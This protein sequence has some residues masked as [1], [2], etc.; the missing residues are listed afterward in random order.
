MRILV[1]DDDNAML[2]AY[3]TAFA[4]AL[5]QDEGAALAQMARA[6]FSE[7]IS[8]DVPS[9]PQVESSNDFSDVSYAT[10]GLEAIELVE[11]SCR[12]GRP[13]QVIFLDMRMPPGISGKEAAR[14]IRQID[15]DVNIVMVTGYSDH[16]PLD[17]ASVAGPLSKLYYIA[18]PF[19][20]DEV[21]Q[22]A[23]ALTDKW[24]IESELR[25]ARATL[26][27]QLDLLRQAHS[28]LAAS[29]AKATHAAFHDFL[30]GAPNRAAFVKTLIELSQ[31][32]PG[33]FSAVLLD[34][35]KFKSV[36]DAL[37]HAAGDE[38]IRIIYQRL[39]SAA[40]VGSMC[41][42]LGGDEFGLILHVSDATAVLAVCDR[43]GMACSTPVP[44]LGRIVQTGASIGVAMTGDLRD[45]ADILRR[46][47]I[48]LYAAKREGRGRTRLYDDSL[49]EST[50][51][52]Q[53]IE[54]ALRSAIEKDELELYFQPIVGRDRL[55][56]VGFEALVRWSSS[57]FGAI[58][59]SL[60]IPIAEESALIHEL[61][62]WVL[63][64]ALAACSQWQGQYVSVNFSPR[65]FRRPRLVEYLIE[66]TKNAGL[67]PDRVQIEITET[68]LFEDIDMAKWILD[69][70][71]EYG[72]HVALDDFGMG[73]SSL[74][75][76]TN[77]NIDCI[78]IDRS[79]VAALGQEGNASAIVTCMS[80]LARSM[81]IDVVAEGVED[82]IQ[83]RALRSSGCSHL[84]GYRYG[85]P[86]N[87]AEALARA[88]ASDATSAGA[89]QGA[90]GHAA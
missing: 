3:R 38:L 24:K 19:E 79:F 83:E 87:A 39:Q 76:L 14:R 8:E 12:E 71:R 32:R 20:I 44:L 69:R 43:I 35:D 90:G 40:P 47:D 18:K 50:R 41:A 73:Y 37:G 77:F 6:L 31:S 56:I 46:A 30:T 54:D 27:E 26:A 82:E 67:T 45:A 66:K 53:Q 74:F 7:D 22:I 61:S 48:A 49:D 51:V 68:A 11:A 86:A 60:F 59:P 13:Y 42:R 55:D 62:D 5:R 25:H 34:L 58:S 1:A 21:L 81:N 9:D 10:Q 84:Q 78:K 88:R 85:M 4:S 17:V 89:Q 63:P 23:R 57:E 2:S 64:R 29:E 80:D 75:N 28:Q 16:A 72:F 33:Q 52:R 36:N 65:Q 15:A 70:L